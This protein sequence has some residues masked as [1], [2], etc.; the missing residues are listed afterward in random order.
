MQVS[1]CTVICTAAH[2]ADYVL[3][4]RVMAGAP[5][6]VCRLLEPQPNLNQAPPDSGS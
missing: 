1:V 6:R 3:W 4:M 2:A 5:L